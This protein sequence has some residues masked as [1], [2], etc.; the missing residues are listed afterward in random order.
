MIGRQSRKILMDFDQVVGR[1]DI[2]RIGALCDRDTRHSCSV[3]RQKTR[4]GIL[5][6]NASPA[7]HTQ[8]SANRQKDLGV[9]FSDTNQIAIDDRAEILS[10]PKTI[11]NHIHVGLRRIRCRGA[12][13]SRFLKASEKVGQPRDLLH[14]RS[15]ILAIN[16]FFLIAQTTYIFLAGGFAKKQTDISIITSRVNLPAIEVSCNGKTM[17]PTQFDP[18]GLVV[19]AIIDHRAIHIKNHGTGF[20][21]RRFRH[22][23][24]FQKPDYINPR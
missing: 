24:P 16:L 11:E 4:S 21:F 10:N 5:K 18:C 23:Y 6:N 3:S 1:L 8:L 7:R 22:F 15:E 14:Y 12:Y 19:S 17:S 13:D 2:L 20:G 9:G